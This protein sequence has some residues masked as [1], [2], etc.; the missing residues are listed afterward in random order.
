[1]N[2]SITEP[3]SLAWQRMVRVC[4]KPFDVG[5]WFVLGFCAWLASL[6][7]GG[8]GFNGSGNP[9][10]GG[11]GGGGGGS[12]CSGCLPQPLLR[13]EQVLQWCFDH[14]VWIVMGAAVLFTLIMIVIA[15][16]LWLRSRGEFMFI[17]GIVKNRG[18]VVEPWHAFRP[19]ANS[20]FY[21]RLA[22]AFVVTSMV[23]AGLF[24]GLFGIWPVLVANL[25]TVYAAGLTP[26]FG[27]FFTVQILLWMG[28][29]F[30]IGFGVMAITGLIN[31]VVD[32]LVVPVMY[33]RDATVGDAWRAVRT[34]LLPGNVGTVVLYYLLLLL[35]TIAA[36]FTTLIVTLFTCCIAALPY[37][38]AVIL[39]P[40]SIFLRAYSLHFVEQFGEG[41]QI[42]R[43][44]D[45]DLLDYP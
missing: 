9:G 44:D 1:M 18:A 37:I 42:F 8:G 31:L 5:K 40:V 17:D 34:E 33:A 12:G 14:V 6:F 7:E 16:V 24:A 25:R 32:H 30:L 26:G 3:I 28:V 39:L 10:G 2:I 22:L 23:F 27:D 19:L 4:F 41:F 43:F 35:L 45:E 38:G 20:V 21:L 11:G 29:F 13:M 15:L 36:G